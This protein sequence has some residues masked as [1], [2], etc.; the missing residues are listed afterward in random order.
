MKEFCQSNLDE[1]DVRYDAAGSND[2]APAS[3]PQII[4]P[5]IVNARF[6]RSFKGQFKFGFKRRKTQ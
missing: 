1:L 4:L 5:K 6:I 2:T 3:T